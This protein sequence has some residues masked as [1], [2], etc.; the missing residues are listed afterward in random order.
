MVQSHIETRDHFITIS[1]TII[2]RKYKYHEFNFI[3]CSSRTDH[4]WRFGNSVFT[5]L[6][7]KA[8]NYGIW[9]NVR[10]KK[11][12]KGYLRYEE[13]ND[14]SKT[15]K[16]ICPT[17]SSTD[18]RIFGYRSHKHLTIYCVRSPDEEKKFSE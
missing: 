12:K 4:Y 11:K 17:Q 18:V 14:S 1:N 6:Q 3:T 9:K 13:I 10:C 16:K 15:K 2:K 8:D 5:S 7:I